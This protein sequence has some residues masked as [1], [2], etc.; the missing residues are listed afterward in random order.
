MQKDSDHMD[1]GV[2]FLLCQVRAD[3]TDKELYCR[4][5]AFL[6]ILCWKAFPMWQAQILHLFQSM[7]ELPLFLLAHFWAS[8]QCLKVLLGE[9]QWKPERLR[10]VLGFCLE[11]PCTVYRIRA[12]Y[13]VEMGFPVF[14]NINLLTLLL[15]HLHFSFPAQLQDWMCG[16]CSREE[17]N[18]PGSAGFLALNNLW[19]REKWSTKKSSPMSG[20]LVSVKQ[21]SWDSVWQPAIW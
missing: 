18:S 6:E 5:T 15:I 2:N 11:S 17:G 9:Q 20:I 7:W 4:A 12:L 21:G 16:P 8:L 1:W 13:P 10:R 19:V 14:S 3:V